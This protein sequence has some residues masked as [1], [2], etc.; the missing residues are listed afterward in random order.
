MTP[1]RRGPEGADS[2]IEASGGAVAVPSRS[3]EADARHT[4]AVVRP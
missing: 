2:V 1:V 3:D 4:H